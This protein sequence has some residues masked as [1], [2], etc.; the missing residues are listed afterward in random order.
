MDPVSALVLYAKA[1]PEQVA[2]GIV[3]VASAIADLT[4][5]KKD[6]KFV[7]KYVRPVASFLSL[8]WLKIFKK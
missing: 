6:D 8:N 5:T 3:F 2:L 7:Q 4:D 1:N